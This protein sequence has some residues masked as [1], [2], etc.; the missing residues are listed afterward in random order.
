MCDPELLLFQAWGG[1]DCV[2]LQ[3]TPEV[4]AWGGLNCVLLQL[5]PE[6]WGGL[7]CVLLQLTPEVWA[8]GGLN[9][10]LLQLTPEAWGGLDCVLLQ[11]TPEVWAWG[12][13]NCVLLQLTPEVWAW[14]GLNCVLLQLT[15]EV[16]VLEEGEG[17][18]FVNH[19]ARTV[20]NGIY[21]GRNFD[22]PLLSLQSL[23]S[24]QTTEGELAIRNVESVDSLQTTEGE[25]A[26]HIWPPSVWGCGEEGALTEQ[27]RWRDWEHRQAEKTQKVKRPGR[28][29]WQDN[30]DKFLLDMVGVETEHPQERP[31]M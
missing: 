5:T 14:G 20:K 25:L 30:P 17:M 22:S 26:I 6:A 15:P 18:M 3:L 31:G 16:W 9:C 11:L 12:G 27:R 13:L 1:L 23:D 24:L 4:W 21:L 19:H 2:L 7:D 10:V 8:W 29:D 28:D